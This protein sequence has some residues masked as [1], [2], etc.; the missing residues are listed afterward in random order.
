MKRNCRLLPTAELNA[1]AVSAA[2]PANTADRA[3]LI[4]A[5][6]P[7]VWRM[8]SRRDRKRQQIEDLAQECVFQL[9]ADLAAFDPAKGAFTTYVGCAMMRAYKYHS[10][11]M[12][13]VVKLPCT[14]GR[15]THAIEVYDAAKS[16]SLKATRIDNLHKLSAPASRDHS[17][18]DWFA[19]HSSRFQSYLLTCDPWDAS[20]LRRRLAGATYDEMAV[21]YGITKQGVQ[22]RTARAI[23]RAQNALR[24]SA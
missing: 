12:N 1:L 9:L 14:T 20:I 17:R 15:S 19:A 10:R 11:W 24:E 2:D 4:E 8:A 23:E 22:Q 16:R 18:W 6:W 21:V 13:P 7:L 5:V 3:R